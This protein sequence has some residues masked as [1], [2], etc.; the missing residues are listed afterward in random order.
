M[1]STLETW[2]REFEQSVRLRDFARGKNLYVTDP[3]LFG[4]RVNQSQEIN[5]YAKN[6]WEKIWTSSIN[7]K[8]LEIL[9]SDENSDLIWVAVLWQNT[10]VVGSEQL[11]RYGRATFILRRIGR[12]LKAVHSHL[13]ENPDPLI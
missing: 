2:L 10:L 4:T 5:A 11:E 6:Q 8:F 9:K 7:F 1:A 3:I 13:S 12:E